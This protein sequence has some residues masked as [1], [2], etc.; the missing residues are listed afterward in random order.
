[1]GKSSLLTRVAEKSQTDQINLVFNLQSAGANLEELGNVLWRTMRRKSDQYPVL[2]QL[3]EPPVPGNICVVLECLAEVAETSGSR[4]TLLLDEGEAL[5]GLAEGDLNRLVAALTISPADLRVVLT[6]SPK[7]NLLNGSA[8]PGNGRLS[9]LSSF[10]FLYIGRFD[11]PEAEALIRQCKNP[12]GCVQADPAL[13]AEIMTLTGNH[14]FLI[15]WLCTRLF[16]SNQRQ[17]RYLTPDDQRVDTPLHLFC[18]DEYNLFS[19]PEIQVLAQLSSSTQSL[20]DLHQMLPEVFG[21]DA[22]VSNLERLGTL[23]LCKGRYSLANSFF[24][25]WLKERLVAKGSN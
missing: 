13:V 8:D 14:P 6:G 18:Q 3:T 5:L 21:L 2:R 23:R 22:M 19:L 12:D 17:L 11:D 1:V 16:D 9:M 20:D 15:Q 24:T 10:E 7:L 4:I 25:N